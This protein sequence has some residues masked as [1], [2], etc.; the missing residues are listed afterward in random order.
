MGHDGDVVARSQPRERQVSCPFRFLEDSKH[1]YY[2]VFDFEIEAT[3]KL[4]STWGAGAPSPGLRKR[5]QCVG[6][7]LMYLRHAWWVGG[8]LAVVGACGA[9]ERKFGADAIGAEGN[10][11][12]ANS[13]C[14]QGL[15]CASNICVTP[16]MGTG[17]AGTGGMTGKMGGAPAGSGGNQMLG[18]S[19][20]AMGGAQAM[21]GAVSG[22]G[23]TPGTSGGSPG[24][25][26]TG[27][28]GAPGAGGGVG[29]P[30]CLAPV[31]IDPTAVD[32]A[33]A[34]FCFGQ[35]YTD[36]FLCAWDGT[37]VPDVTRC[38]VGVNVA[39]FVVWDESGANLGNAY[40]QQDVNLTSPLAILG[41]DA[42]G[43]FQVLWANG[44]YG[45]C[46]VIGNQLQ[47]CVTPV[48]TT[49]P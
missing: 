27:T 29:M 40:N 7:R 34:A 17:G 21:G 38:S 30:S 5:A 31:Q 9:P 42:N 26:G 25:G 14:N 2:L 10:A 11:C 20:G 37:G 8:L 18:G 36:T 39:Y 19:P 35:A 6:I 46:Q 3:E 23:G 12:F 43:V 47:L 1:A 15:A 16:G 24:V 33:T 48:A 41:K 4:G 13:T 45:E 22:A 49:A 32:K 28:G 44:D